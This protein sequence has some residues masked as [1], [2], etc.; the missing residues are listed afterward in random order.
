MSVYAFNSKFLHFLSHQRDY[1][2]ASGA[3]NFINLKILKHFITSITQNMDIILFS[4]LDFFADLMGHKQQ[5]KSPWL[6]FQIN[7]LNLAIY[8][9]E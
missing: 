3:I 4:V 7:K 1:F 9:N 8:L 5:K 2:A 6:W